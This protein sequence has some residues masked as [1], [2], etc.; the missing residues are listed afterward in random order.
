MLPGCNFSELQTH[1][2]KCR[3]IIYLNDTVC[4][5]CGSSSA[6]DN[7]YFTSI[8]REDGS[9]YMVA[10]DIFDFNESVELPSYN[11]I[12][13]LFNNSCKVSLCEVA[14]DTCAETEVVNFDESWFDDLLDALLFELLPGFYHLGIFRFKFV[15]QGCDG[16]RSHIYWDE[17][18]IGCPDWPCCVRLIDHEKIINVLSLR[19]YTEPAR[20]LK[21]NKAR[22]EQHRIWRSMA[23]Q[24]MDGI[25]DDKS[26]SIEG[27]HEILSKGYPDKDSQVLS[28]LSWYAHSGE[29]LPD[30]KYVTIE[31]L[32]AQILESYNPEIIALSLKSNSITE[33]QVLGLK[34]LIN[35]NPINKE[36]LQDLIFTLKNDS[37][38]CG[39]IGSLFQDLPQKR[40]WNGGL[41]LDP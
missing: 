15:F 33:S 2:H 22:V 19:G 34:F 38:I 7:S 31:D 5:H 13:E 39:S 35:R 36:W 41:L 24:G 37:M 6:D 18:I 27:I 32:P 26:F 1:C 25:L 21:K 9:S 20:N 11:Y 4:P 30:N 29:S 10:R 16:K 28:L 23:P 40:I 8:L 12:T 3:T 14:T 17:N